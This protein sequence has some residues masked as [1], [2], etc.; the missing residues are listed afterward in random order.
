MDDHP[1]SATDLT[2][3]QKRARL[4]QLLQQRG[5]VQPPPAQFVFAP[6]F[7]LLRKAQ[8][9]PPPLGIK[10]LYNCECEGTNGATTVI[11]GRELINFSSYNYLGLSGDSTISAAAK[12]AID[13][14]GTSVSASRVASGQRPL[15]RALEEAI[16]GFIGAEAALA[17]VGGFSTNQT[18]VAHL[19]GP[20]DLILHDS[21][22][23]SSIQQGA[24][25]SGATVIPFPHNNP[26][27]L[28]TILARQRAE[29]RQALIVIEGVYSMDGDLPDLARFIEIKRR[30]GALLM[31]DEAHSI[32]TLGAT[33]R[34]IA[35]HQAV[36]P[37]AVDIWMGT[38]S[39]ALASCGGYIA[40]TRALIDYLRLSAPGF[41][42]SVGLTPPD[43]AAALA[44]LSKLR[45][46]P[47]RVTRLQARA[48]HF[49]E[50]ARLQ[51]LDTGPSHDSPVVPVMTGD[52]RRAVHLSHLLFER[53]IL[54]LPIS[55]PAVPENKSRLRFFLSC[56]HD[57]AQ[58]D[59]TIRALGESM[60][61]LG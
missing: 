33:G 54:A 32:G 55:Y 29:G 8:E 22:I 3:E 48:A 27:A 30:H 19:F 60:Q 7:D 42:Y 59:H 28:D 16:A 17:F 26:A 45:D 11:G 52:G 24:R 23:H 20:E 34:G 58:I 14:Y 36:D 35:E 5:A 38:L 51:G 43:T 10:G 46:E 37:S 2:P 39:K 50:R 56:D 41:I 12:A 4:A 25:Q 47:G 15:H 61:E 57:E 53:G 49:L 31:V 6:E 13:R 40:G 18:V 9:L 44:A 1:V 21:L